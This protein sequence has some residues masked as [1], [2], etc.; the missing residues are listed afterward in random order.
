MTTT[1]PHLEETADLGQWPL[2]CHTGRKLPTLDSDHY[3]ATPGGNRRP[4]TV[5]TTLPHREETADLGQ[6]PLPCHTWRK[7]PTLD[8]DHYLATPGGNRR[9]W[10]VTTTLPHLEETADL[11]Q[12]PLACHTWRKPPT[13]DSDHYPATPGG[14][15]RPWTVTTTLLHADAW[16]RFRLS[17][18][19]EPN[20]FTGGSLH[21]LY[22][23]STGPQFRCAFTFWSKHHE[24]QQK[25]QQHSR[26]FA[27]VGACFDLAQYLPSRIALHWKPSKSVVIA[28][29]EIHEH[30]ST[31]AAAQQRSTSA[32]ESCRQRCGDSSATQLNFCYTFC[33]PI[34]SV[35]AISALPPRLYNLWIAQPWRSCRFSCVSSV[36]M[37]RS[38]DCHCAT[39]DQGI[40][41]LHF[42]CYLHYLLALKMLHNSWFSRFKMP[43]HWKRKAKSKP[44]PAQ[45]TTVTQPE[46]QEW[47]SQAPALQAPAPQAEPD[48][49]PPECPNWSL[50]SADNQGRT[51]NLLALLLLGW[52][53]SSSLVSL[54]FIIVS[55]IIATGAILL[56]ILF[57]GWGQLL[58]N[59][60]F[61]PIYVEA[62]PKRNISAALA[63]RS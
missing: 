56:F 42:H 7:P 60:D 6:W 16:N 31:E 32:M 15:H 39:A 30:S 18:E 49:P 8:S 25:L 36:L 43:T 12:W 26:S 10:T 22:P 44:G 55:C 1:L 45:D 51:Q 57:K 29:H 47:A 19:S 9:P 24:L 62:V 28:K 34:Y 54:W 63:L 27:V 38:D 17:S 23:R 46:L 59:L 2:P 11:G 33:A 20:F 58:L 41:R 50:L 52:F 40:K 61:P 13:L 48:P 14:N 5:T 21:V 53:S 35:V 3:P 4:W 37:L